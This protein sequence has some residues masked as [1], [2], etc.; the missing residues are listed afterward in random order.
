MKAFSDALARGSVRRTIGE[1]ADDPEDR[2]QRHGDRRDDQRQLEGVDGLRRRERVP[3]RR[4]SRPRTSGRRRA[5]AARRGS[6]AGSRSATSAEAELPDEP[7][8]RSCLV[9]KWRIAPIESSRP[10]EI[11]SRTTA[12]AAAPA[13]SPLSI[14]PK[15]KTEET[16]RLVGQVAGDDHERAELADR[17]RE[18][19]RDAG[20]DPGQDVRE[21]DA[22]E[23]RQLDAPSDFAACSISRSSSSSTGCTVRT[24]NGSV[25]NSSA[26]TIARRRVGDVDPDRRLR[27]RRAR[28]ASARR[29]SS[30][31][32]TAGR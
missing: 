18:R 19:E 20:E 29:R 3:G 4:R 12:T 31:A 5:R 9:A 14:R 17:L 30:A 15:M 21:D 16:S 23:R 24:T 22:A 7:S 10:N 27:A 6:P 11:A 8:A 25:T 28:A 2:V 1:P 32:R 26:S 13:L